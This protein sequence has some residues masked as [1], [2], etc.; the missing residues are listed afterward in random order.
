MT[1]PLNTRHGGGHVTPPIE[2][3]LDPD[4]ELWLAWAPL[5]DDMGSCQYGACESDEAC[6][7]QEALGE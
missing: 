4:P 2:A 6:T 3:L 1:E 7:C 5:T